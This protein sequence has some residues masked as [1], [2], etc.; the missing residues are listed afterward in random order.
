[1]TLRMILP[2][3]GYPVVSRRRDVWDKANKHQGIGRMNEGKTS[4]GWKS[5]AL[6]L[7]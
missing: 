7:N 4:Q 6:A 3:K 1:M 5:M 2:S